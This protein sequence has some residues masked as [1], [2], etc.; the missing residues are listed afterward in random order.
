M[1]KRMSNVDSEEKAKLLEMF[2]EVG[3]STYRNLL[4]HRI[5]LLN[6]EIKE[7]IIE[8]I[9][10]PLIQLSK[11]NPRKPITL[12]IN[13]EGGNHEDAQA[14]V[15]TIMYSKTHITTLVLGK[16]MS[17]AFDIFLAG[18][19]RIVHANSLLMCHCGTENP[20]NKTLPN[21]ISDA[22][23]L[24][25][26]LERWAKFYASRTKI[27]ESEWLQIMESSKDR[28]FFPEEA[29]LKGIAHEIHQPRT[30]KL[31][32]THIRKKKSNRSKR[33]K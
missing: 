19:H 21:H 26:Y 6:G 5:I 9:V 25:T 12:V 33:N 3:I 8:R 14:V 31:Q 27:S 24:Q 29:V 22:K 18:D 4:K 11:A 15:D 13:S 7:N 1:G 23:L 2:S 20:G 30:E 32:P 17:A 28:Y 16:A 10:F